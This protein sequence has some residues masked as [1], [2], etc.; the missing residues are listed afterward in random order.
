LQLPSSLIR[1]RDGIKRRYQSYLSA[2]SFCLERWQA[3]F[4][5][6]YSLVVSSCLVNA[7]AAFAAVIHSSA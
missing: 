6:C 2:S 3:R 1:D 7:V 4:S 5:E